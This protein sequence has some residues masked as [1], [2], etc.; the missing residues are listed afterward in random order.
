MLCNM[1]FYFPI[2]K[3]VQRGVYVPAGDPSSAISRL[4]AATAA[5]ATAKEQ[6][7]PRQAPLRVQLTGAKVHNN[8]TTTTNDDDDGDDDGL[9]RRT[10]SFK[11]TGVFA[12]QYSKLNCHCDRGA[13]GFASG[14][15]CASSA[16][17][18]FARTHA[19]AHAPTRSVRTHAPHSPLCSA[20]QRT[21]ARARGRATTTTNTRTKCNKVV[22][23]KQSDPPAA[24]ARSGPDHV[25]LVLRANS[26]GSPAAA[27]AAGIDMSLL[28]GAGPHRR[29]HADGE[30][31]AAK[32]RHEPTGSA[33][34]S[35][36][37]SSPPPSYW[38]LDDWSFG[39]TEV[40]DGEHEQ[41][42]ASPATPMCVRLNCV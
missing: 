22:P 2:D 29:A 33:D 30:A 23:A 4:T 31:A 18:S 13:G 15:C 11:I 35:V 5:A 19:R 16:R 36:S 38:S 12:A 32:T 21:H 20:R 3:M 41:A 34:G 17:L 6:S 26:L 24:P 25:A 37:S 8:A 40:Y 1:P 14:G 10:F 39:K 9:E 7:L 27:F 42:F 28:G